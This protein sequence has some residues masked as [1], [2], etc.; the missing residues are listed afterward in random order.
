MGFNCVKN[1]VANKHAKKEYKAPV[2][3][4]NKKGRAPTLPFPV[5]RVQTVTGA[6]LTT[7]SNLAA[8]RC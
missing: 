5:F 7:R 4:P 3:P 1:F 8:G 6:S 2:R